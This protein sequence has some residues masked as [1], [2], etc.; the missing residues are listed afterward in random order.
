MNQSPRTPQKANHDT[1]SSYAV[2]FLLSLVFTIIPYYI[3]VNKTASSS[4][5]LAMILGFGVVQ[6][7]VQVVFFLHLGRGPKPLYNLVFFGFTIVTILV[8]V[9]G[10]IFIM[11]NLHYNMTQAEATKRLAQDENIYQVEGTQTGACQQTRSN[12]T[13]TIANNRVTPIHTDAT[14]CDTLT[15]INQDDNVREIGFGEHPQHSGYAGQD[16]FFLRQNRGK[17]ITLNQ[18]GTYSFHDHL[19]PNVNGS[20]TVKP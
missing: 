16:D 18:L 4:T 1:I 12:H 13:I 11:N 17:T 8:V 7:L 19:D 14:P 6:M 9:G 3:V 20:F 15:F 5:L 2:G 10:S